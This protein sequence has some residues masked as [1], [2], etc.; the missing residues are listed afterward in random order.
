[1]DTGSER[2]PSIVDPQLWASLARD[3]AAVTEAPDEPRWLAA[4]VGSVSARLPGRSVVVLTARPGSPTLVAAEASADWVERCP[5][6]LLLTAAETERACLR[7]GDFTPLPAATGMTTGSVE[8][9][10]AGFRTAE[11]TGLVALERTAGAAAPLAADQGAAEVLAAVLGVALSGW[12][13]HQAAAQQAAVADTLLRETDVLALVVD[14]E[15]RIRHANPALLRITGGTP[16]AL[17]GMPLARWLGP[18]AEHILLHVVLEA[19][20]GRPTTG[21]VAPLPQPTGGQTAAVFTAAALHDP[22][23]SVSGVALMGLGLRHLGELTARHEARAARWGQV[24]AG[25]SA[26]LADPLR[27]L[28]GL[29]GQLAGAPGPGADPG[30]WPALLAASA[31]LVRLLRR[32]LEGLGA[33][34]GESAGPPETLSLNALVEEALREAAPLLAARGGR[35]RTALAGELP[36][37]VGLRAGLRAALVH[38]VRNAAEAIPPGGRL[39]LRT[40]DNRD[41]TVGASISDTG[42]G[43]PEEHLARL[44]TPFHTLR[45]DPEHLGLGL[46]VVKHLID[47]HDGTVDI[48]S[49]EGEGTV[50]TITLPT[51]RPR[52]EPGSEMAR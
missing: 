22:E 50:V 38:L 23:H 4:V 43:I 16:E 19:L 48:D 47:L 7:P 49:A 15:A 3:V 37:L 27:A 17:V 24:A 45:P 2:N 1:L 28:E 39:T 41:G 18:G 44:G 8:L 52:P 13:R 5:D 6:A 14:R 26:R 11:A 25:M 35:T 46:A 20:A 33:L 30:A 51:Q 40:W 32:L 9:A 29:H 12:R 21:F 42:A 34:A 36:E 10:R 31:H